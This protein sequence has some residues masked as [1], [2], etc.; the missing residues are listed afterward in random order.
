MLCILPLLQ[1]VIPIGVDH[2]RELL[3]RGN[4][5][6]DQ[7]FEALKVDVRIT[8]SVDNQELA[9]EAVRPGFRRAVPVAL[10]VLLE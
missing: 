9:F 10:Y 2:H 6:V 5:F 7:R 3:F 4:Q 1:S 8:G